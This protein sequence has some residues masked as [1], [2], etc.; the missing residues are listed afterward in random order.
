MEESSMKKFYYIL[1]YVS[2]TSPS[3]AEAIEK[4]VG[5]YTQTIGEQK[6]VSYISK[7]YRSTKA[8]EIVRN[9]LAASKISKLAPHLIASV[10]AVESGFSQ[11][12]HSR[13]GARGLMQIIPKYHKDKLK[14][15]NV[16]DIATNI[17]VGAAILAEYI[18]DQRSLPLGLQR[19][20][21]SLGDRKLTF[22]HKVKREALRLKNWSNHGS[23]N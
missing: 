9:I 2:L 8:K 5:F 3:L 12:S 19:Y 13:E 18:E 22:Y 20:N 23:R 16:Y 7:K 1:L 17:R 11:Y 21:S 14:G 4:R 10:A 15:R 6:L